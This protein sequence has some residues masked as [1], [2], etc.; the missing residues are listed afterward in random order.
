MAFRQWSMTEIGV[1]LKA[2]S[3]TLF[4][5]CVTDCLN[6]WSTLAVSISGTMPN[7]VKAFK[8]T[9]MQPLASTSA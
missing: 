6:S 9:M 5:A 4:M 2:E 7:A 8:V 3:R 1:S